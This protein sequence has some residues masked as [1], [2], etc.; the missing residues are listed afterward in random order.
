VFEAV[1]VAISLEEPE[2]LAMGVALLAKFLSVCPRT[3]EQRS[4]FR[5]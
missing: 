5:M 3:G 1:A 2:L 4:P